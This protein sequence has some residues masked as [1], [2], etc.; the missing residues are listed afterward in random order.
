M[1]HVFQVFSK[2]LLS[3]YAY[4]VRCCL[5]HHYDLSGINTL[6]IS[7]PSPL[8]VK[9]KNFKL[10]FLFFGFFFSGWWRCISGSWRH[11]EHPQTQTQ[12]GRHPQQGDHH[13]QDGDPRDHEGQL[14]VFHAEGDLR[15]ARVRRKHHARPYQFRERSGCSGR[16]QGLPRGNPSVPPSFAD[17]VRNFLPLGHRHQ[18]TPRGTHRTPRDDWPRVWFPWQ[19]HSHFQ[20]RRLLFHFAVRRDG[21][22]PHGSPL[23][24]VPQRPHRRNHKHRRFE[25]LSGKSLRCPH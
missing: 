16:H 25:H 21:R 20:G 9:F 12:C 11:P 10:L 2:I 17:C 5:I 18:T 24:Q 3:N 6:E 8:W 14:L 4:W 7:C 22:H 15:T 13:P 23:L 19:K 1:G